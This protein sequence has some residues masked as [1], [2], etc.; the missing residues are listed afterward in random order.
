MMSTDTKTYQKF[1]DEMILRD[2]LALDRTILANK[3]TFLA[4]VRTAIGLLASGIGMVKLV[5]DG[6]LNILG[7][8]FIIAALPVLI[9]GTTEYIKIR[10]TLRAVGKIDKIEIKNL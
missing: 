1:C 3:R 7:F 9:I 10:I 8:V 2:Y 5:S 4:Y 6:I